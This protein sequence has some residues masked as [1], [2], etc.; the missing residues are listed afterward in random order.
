MTVQEFLKQCDDAEQR[1][2]DKSSAGFVITIPRIRMGT[3]A[4]VAP[5]L[6]G[7]VVSHF[8]E[9]PTRTAVW[10][11][12]ADVRRACAKHAKKR[13]SEATSCPT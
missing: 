9:D 10:L 3:K 6:M 5:G 1:Y 2:E 8:C 12:C 7:R 13:P 11:S 4:R